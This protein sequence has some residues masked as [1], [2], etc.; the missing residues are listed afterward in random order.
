MS[1]RPVNKPVRPLPPADG[2]ARTDQ[3][4]LFPVLVVLGCV[5]G[6]ALVIISCAGTAGALVVLALGAGVAFIGL[7]YLLWG[8]WLSARMRDTPDRDQTD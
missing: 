3:G 6:A 2:A 1:E 7:Q 8:R 4:S 5:L